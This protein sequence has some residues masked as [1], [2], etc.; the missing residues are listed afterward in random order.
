M[1]KRCSIRCK[2]VTVNGNKCKNPTCKTG[3]CWQHLRSQ[4]KLRVKE[5]EIEDAGDGLF[6][7]KSKKKDPKVVFDKD[8]KITKYTGKIYNS[9]KELD[10]SGTDPSYILQVGKHYVD[11]IDPHSGPARYA[12]D[13]HNSDKQCNAKFTPEGDIV[14]KKPIKDG[15]EILTSYGKAY[16]KWK[17]ENKQLPP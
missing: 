17:S 7:A 9:K 2:A 5:S 8:E 4:Q 16:W 3:Y 6:A 11:A 14:A 10:E 15:Q 1:P 12:N 13:C